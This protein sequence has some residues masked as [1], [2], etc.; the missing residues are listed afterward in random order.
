[1]SNFKRRLLTWRC[2]GWFIAVAQPA[3]GAA[4]VGRNEQGPVPFAAEVSLLAIGPIRAATNIIVL[5]RQI[6]HG[7]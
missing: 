6:K 1:M 5:Q 2:C 3:V 4:L 7:F